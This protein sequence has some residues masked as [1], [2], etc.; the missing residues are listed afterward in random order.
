MECSTLHLQATGALPTL[1]D[2]GLRPGTPGKL[3]VL[4]VLSLL[5][6]VGSKFKNSLTYFWLKNL[7]PPFPSPTIPVGNFPA[8]SLLLPSPLVLFLLLS[9]RVF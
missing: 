5:T 6:P 8:S 4:W 2:L 1:F 3:P 7:S 9:L